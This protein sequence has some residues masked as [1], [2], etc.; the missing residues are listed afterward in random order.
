MEQPA[1]NSESIFP[2]FFA[3]F[4]TG[5]LLLTSFHIKLLASTKQCTNAWTNYR[6]WSSVLLTGVQKLL[7]DHA[8]FNQITEH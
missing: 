5:N 2:T 8:F 4:L 1:R 3:I 6:S 7:P